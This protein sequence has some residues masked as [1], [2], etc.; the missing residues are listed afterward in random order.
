MAEK[1]SVIIIKRITKGGHGHHGGAWKVAYADFVTA[2][3]AFFMVMWLMGSDEETKQAIAQYF[4]HPVAPWNIE[5]SKLNTIPIG[6]RSGPGE[7]VL[8]GLDGMN[9]DDAIRSINKPSAA[10]IEMGEIDSLAKKL[11]EGRIPEIDGAVERLEFSMPEK[12]LFK[13]DTN[14]VA[15]EATKFLERLGKT[16]KP[17]DGYLGVR[18]EFGGAHGGNF[19]TYESAMERAVNLADHL[20]RKKYI[21]EERVRPRVLKA[22]AP[23]H[24]E[25]RVYF[26]LSKKPI[27]D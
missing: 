12:L 10:A 22:P 13:P 17:F 7:S 19:D 5:A 3:M 23:A 15:T 18:A 25:R 26:T 20:V 16:L 8:K 9:P 6:E 27:Q 4:N 24:E 11:A 1:Q 14:Q 21:D 2:M